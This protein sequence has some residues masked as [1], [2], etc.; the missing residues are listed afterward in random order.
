MT[1]KPGRFPVGEPS[2][3]SVFAA[4]VRAQERAIARASAVAGAGARV[5]PTGDK[6][7]AHAERRK[8]TT[9]GT[10]HTVDDG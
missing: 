9:T 8:P 6:P 7:A 1:G 3:K 5:E 4:L 2:V 10:G